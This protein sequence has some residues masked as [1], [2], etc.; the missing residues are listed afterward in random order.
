MHVYGTFGY[1]SPSAAAAT[2]CW[3]AWTP[4]WRT[5]SADCFLESLAEWRTPRPL[6]ALDPTGSHA[7][8][9]EI[10]G[11]LGTCPSHRRKTPSADSP[12]ACSEIFSKKKHNC[13]ARQVADCQAVHTYALDGAAD[14]LWR[15]GKARGAATV[16]VGRGL[17]GDAVRSGD[18]VDLV[19]PHEDA[20]F[21]G[22]VDL[23][24]GRCRL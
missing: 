17:L 23:P 9:I 24:A 22:D 14:V 18:L 5:S 11:A 15:C 8:G 13:H 19:A 20:R 3:R 4:C 21:D 1:R 10:E 7:E 16:G 6:G 2:K 12:S